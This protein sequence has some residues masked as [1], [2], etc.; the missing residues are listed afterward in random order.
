MRKKIK[1]IDGLSRKAK[2]NIFIAVFL[3]FIVA[4]IFFSVNQIISIIEKR[5]KIVELEEKLSWI[6]NNNIEILALE[7]SL[8]HDDTI[9]MEARKQFNMAYGSE[10]NLF[11]VIEDEEEI[12]QT[13]LNNS[14]GLKKGVYSNTNLWENIK[15]FY[16]K[17]INNN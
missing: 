10:T 1:V 4:V 2:I 11:V 9:E 7:K 6:R 17:E 3:V 16:N 15:I 12:N 8:Y 13:N 14:N 5:E